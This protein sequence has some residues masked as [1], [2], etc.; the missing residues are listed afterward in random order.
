MPPRLIRKIADKDL[1]FYVI[2]ANRIAKEVGMPK[3]TNT[4][5]QVAF[6]KLSKIIPTD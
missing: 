2:D 5:M 1:K 6:F 3:R 4:V